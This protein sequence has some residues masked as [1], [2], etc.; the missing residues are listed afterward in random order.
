MKTRR[1]ATF[2]VLVSVILTA[3]LLP[4]GELPVEALEPGHSRTAGVGASAYRNIPS[5]SP[6][7]WATDLGKDGSMD[8]LGRSREGH[9]IAWWQNDASQS[10]SQLPL[11][12]VPNA[13]QTN[14]AVRFQVRGMGGTLFFTPREVVLSLPTPAGARRQ[15][16]DASG[17]FARLREQPL[18]AKV[19]PTTVVR[20]RFEGAN[21]ALSLIHI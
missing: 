15:Q 8:V 17:A 1:F 2:G 20:L 18:T 19:A 10:F 14:P 5:Q 13:G 9:E 21:Q 6:T 3:L 7:S 16:E 12:F 11:S 4:A